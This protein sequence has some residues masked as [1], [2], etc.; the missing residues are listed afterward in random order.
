ME[1]ILLWIIGIF[2]LIISV[3][4]W[5]FRKIPS[6]L[7]TAFIIVVFVLNMN[8]A[9]IG[10]VGFLFA[11]LLMEFDYFKG[12]AD[13]KVFTMLAL[14]CSTFNMFIFYLAI[15]MIIG[16]SWKGIIKWKF[17]SE[18]EFA[19]IPVFF[20]TYLVLVLGGVL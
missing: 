4:D 6:V 3:I 15:F 18:E 10:V 5:K 20:F 7:L 11:Y 2:L 14:L 19:F 12:L 1:N 9:L 8:N 17:P 13:V 16:I